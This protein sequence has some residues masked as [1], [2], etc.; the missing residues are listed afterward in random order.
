MAQNWGG[1]IPL[2]TMLD[3]VYSSGYYSAIFKL[4]GQLAAIYPDFQ[5]IK[6]WAETQGVVTLNWSLETHFPNVP[7]PTL[8]SDQGLQTRPYMV[9]ICVSIDL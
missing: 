3:D 4:W 9:S 8:T 2:K 1:L 7:D 6:S 5:A